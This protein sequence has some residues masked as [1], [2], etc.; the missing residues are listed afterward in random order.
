MGD[1]YAFYLS[2]DKN[3]GGV[4]NV[5]LKDIDD[6]RKA[7]FTLNRLIN[8]CILGIEEPVPEQVRA[9]GKEAD[10]VKKE[11]SPAVTEKGPFRPPAEP[12]GKSG[13]L[14]LRCDACGDIF[15]A[16]PRGYRTSWGCRCGHQID[17]DKPFAKYSFTCPH[18]GEFRWG[19]TNLENPEIEVSCKC[20]KK[21]VLRWDPEK[22]KYLNGF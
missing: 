4:F 16:A 10:P 22:K 18:C 2:V 14:L 7:Q 20:G 6:P 19:Q 12:A 1:K 21:T 17:L 15:L 5:G 11:T 9:E 13:V 8:E 3:R